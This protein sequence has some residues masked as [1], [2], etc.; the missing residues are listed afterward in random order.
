MDN[1]VVYSCVIASI[2]YVSRLFP[3]FV[4]LDHMSSKWVE[5]GVAD[6]LYDCCCEHCHSSGVSSKTSFYNRLC[7]RH[8]FL[9]QFRNLEDAGLS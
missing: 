5:D 9:I 2:R 3:M 8:Q 4:V 7:F 6:S 1:D